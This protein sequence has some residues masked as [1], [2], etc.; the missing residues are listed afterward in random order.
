MDRSPVL[1]VTVNTRQKKS[2][3]AH[4]D[5][6]EL[7]RDTWAVT[8]DWRVGWYVVMPEHLHF[9]CSPRGD[10]A[11][12]ARWMSFWKGL[13]SCRWPRPGEQPI[14]Q[15]D[16]WDTQLRRNESYEEKWEYMRMNPVRRALVNNPDDWPFAGRIHD[17]SW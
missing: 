12:L 17:L 11:S 13:V 7:L 10:R 3:L 14:W 16:F 1:F 2:I 6:H 15:R 8:D 9:L 4:D 5:V